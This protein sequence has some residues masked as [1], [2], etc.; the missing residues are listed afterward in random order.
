MS[1]LSETLKACEKCFDEAKK[2]EKQFKA[3]KSP[4]DKEKLKK[5]AEAA[6]KMGVA[7]YDM[8]PAAKDKDKKEM[9]SATRSSAPSRGACRISRKQPA[10][11]VPSGPALDREPLL[12]RSHY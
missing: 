4:Q 7:Y 10:C 8:I 3:A 11:G 9:I 12:S 6:K 2:L 5:M 1:H